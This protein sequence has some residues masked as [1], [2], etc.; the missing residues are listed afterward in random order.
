MAEDSHM[1][2]L[3]ERADRLTHKKTHDQYFVDKLKEQVGFDGVDLLQLR[4]KSGHRKT[5]PNF[6]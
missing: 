3:E 6:A 5:L 2:K 4:I 1:K